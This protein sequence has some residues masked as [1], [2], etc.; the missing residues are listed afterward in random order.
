MANTFDAVDETGRVVTG[1]AIIGASVPRID[2]PMKTTGVAQYAADY[3]FDRLAHAVPVQ[4]TIAS[5][6]IKRLDVSAAEKMPGVLLVLHHGNLAPADK[7][8]RVVPNDFSATVSEARPAFE[9]EKIY[10]WG[11]YVAVVVAETLEQATAASKA[12]QMEYETTPHS[13]RRSLNDYTGKRKSVSKRGDP[14]K[15]FAT[16]SVKI[17]QNYITPIETHN[18]I[19]MHATMATRSPCM[20]LRREF[21]IIVWLSR[22]SSACRAKM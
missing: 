21:G 15:A 2:G 11:Q 8:Y 3:H 12:V 1:A 17:D 13:L 5:G 20:R 22:R 10:Y 4:S 18:P 7:L 6:S 16:A 9:D 19:E 14:D